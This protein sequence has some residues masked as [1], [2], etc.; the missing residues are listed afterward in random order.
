MRSDP[1]CFPH[2]VPTASVADRSLLQSGRLPGP[3]F[4]YLECSSFKLRLALVLQQ[5][6]SSSLLDVRVM[7]EL[8]VEACSSLQQAAKLLSMC[9]S[10]CLS[11]C[12]SP[13][14][15][16]SWKVQ[17]AKH[18]DINKLLEESTSTVIKSLDNMGASCFLPHHHKKPISPADDR[19]NKSCPGFKQSSLQIFYMK[20]K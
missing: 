15:P 13:S 6:S 20:H 1:S 11:A 3:V 10:E 14:L 8:Q 9:L 17:L 7:L 4:A 12:Q 18:W 5:P 19:S 2:L 16:N